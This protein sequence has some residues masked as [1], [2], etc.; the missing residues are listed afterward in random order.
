MMV[1]ELLKLKNREIA[2]LEKIID[3]I[4]RKISNGRWDEIDE[5]IDHLLNNQKPEPPK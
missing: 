5:K 2:T 4:A 3:R 1:K